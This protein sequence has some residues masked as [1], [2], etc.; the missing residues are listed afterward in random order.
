MLGFMGLPAAL[1]NNVHLIAFALG[2]FQNIKPVVHTPS[3]LLDQVAVK[4]ANV[5]RDTT[6]QRQ[7]ALVSSVR[8]EVTVPEIKI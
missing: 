4:I 1:A 3:Q 5:C 2:G 8:L 6:P 7:E